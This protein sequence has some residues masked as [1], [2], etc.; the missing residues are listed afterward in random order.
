MLSATP[1]Q[2]FQT[3]GR[4]YISEH[5]EISSGLET[6]VNRTV[7]FVLVIRKKQTALIFLRPPYIEILLSS[8]RIKP[9]VYKYMYKQMYCS[10]KLS[11]CLS[12]KDWAVS[13]LRFFIRAR[14]RDML[15]G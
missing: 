9:Y 13:L 8:Q 5:Q 7:I 11:H 3:L 6:G 2:L 14:V 10:S 12:L 1:T 15:S 4:L